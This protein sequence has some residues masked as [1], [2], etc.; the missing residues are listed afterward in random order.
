MRTTAM[1]G[2]VGRR[3]CFFE[4]PPSPGVRDVAAAAAEG[5]FWR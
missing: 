1:S 2:S 3:G 5:T 4:D